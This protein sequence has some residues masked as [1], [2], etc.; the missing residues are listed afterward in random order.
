MNT[1]SEQAEL[2]TV[3]CPRHLDQVGF[4][5]AEFWV[6]QSIGKFAIVGYDQQPF[7]KLIESTHVIDSLG[8]GDQIDNA[9]SACR[10]RCGGNDSRRLIDNEIFFSF[11]L[12]TLTIDI[13]H[14][15]V[16]I[17]FGAK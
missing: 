11:R 13:D 4:M 8:R 3:R 7:A 9:C 1:P 6:S 16:R 2:L 15:F 14:L 12:D 5:D 17:D 10:I